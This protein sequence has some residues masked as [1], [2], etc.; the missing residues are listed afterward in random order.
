MEQKKLME[1]QKKLKKQQE[2][3]RKQSEL[4]HMLMKALPFKFPHHHQRRLPSLR[5]QNQNGDAKNHG[6]GSKKNYGGEGSNNVSEWDQGRDAKQPSSSDQKINVSENDLG[7]DGEEKVDDDNNDNGAE[8]GNVVVAVDEQKDSKTSKKRFNKKKSEADDKSVKSDKKDEDYLTMMTL[9]E[10]EKELEKRKASDEKT[11]LESKETLDNA[12]ES[13]PEERKLTL[14]KDFDSMQLLQNETHEDDALFIK[15]V[16]KHIKRVRG[17][18]QQEGERPN[19]GQQSINGERPVGGPYRREKWRAPNA[20]PQFNGERP[21]S[22]NGE[23]RYDGERPNSNGHGV[24]GK[25]PDGRRYYGE[26]PHSS[27]RGHG[28]E[29]KEPNGRR[30]SKGPN[31]DQGERRSGSGGSNG[32]VHDLTLKDSRKFP[33]I[34]DTNQFPALGGARKA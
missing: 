14:D 6:E 9:A 23:P 10:Y 8:G 2:R 28:V 33:D 1:M 18:S 29:G 15:V 12:L 22:G 30:E 13:D 27:T 7:G 31:G 26:R 25:K 4:T 20:G 24:E 17:A 5:Q 21:R 32:P 34:E 3:E 16:S 19:G 11:D